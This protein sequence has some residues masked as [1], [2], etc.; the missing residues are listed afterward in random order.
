M[1]NDEMIFNNGLVEGISA[2]RFALTTV[3]RNGMEQLASL[4]RKAWSRYDL[5]V[6]K[7]QVQKF[8]EF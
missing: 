7:Q 6:S 1:I 8:Q 4:E 3:I 5:L 2:V